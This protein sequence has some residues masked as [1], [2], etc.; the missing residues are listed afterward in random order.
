MFTTV[1]L[2]SYSC[3]QMISVTVTG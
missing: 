3:F 2:Q 1:V